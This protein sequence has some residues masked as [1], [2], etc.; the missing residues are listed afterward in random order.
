MSFEQITPSI[1]SRTGF[2]FATFVFMSV[3]S[4]CASE[5]QPPQVGSKAPAFSLKDLSG[6]QVELGE[7]TKKGPVVVVVLRGYPGYQCPLCT[8][9]VGE[10][11]K[12]AEI[13]RAG[14]AEVIFVY[15]GAS[16]SL[17][18]FAGE[19][20]KSFHLPDGF[21]LVVDPDYSMINAYKL[22]WNAP[23]ETAYPSTFVVNAGGEIVYAK[24]SQSHGDRADAKSVIGSITK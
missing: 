19:F 14:K 21:H 17:E 10:F 22:R 4:V 8:R 18:K 20:V 15:P 2:S 12:A 6:N 24:V 9:Q 11:I 7:L 23:K 5:P 3:F 1:L 16:K 13:F